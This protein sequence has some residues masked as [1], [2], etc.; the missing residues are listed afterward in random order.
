MREVKSSWLREFRFYALPQSSISWEESKT[1]GKYSV[2]NE[3]G[4]QIEVK[5]LLGLCGL[6]EGQ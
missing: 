5:G 4:E 1:F 6:A 3:T 2:K